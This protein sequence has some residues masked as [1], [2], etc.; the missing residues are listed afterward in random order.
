MIDT[1]GLKVVTVGC[2]GGSGSRLLRDILEASPQIFMDQDC[3]PNSKDSQGSKIFLDLMDAPSET[4]RQLIEDFMQTI[5]RQIP[6]GHESRYKYFGWKNPRN[7]KYVDELLAIHPE[8]RFLHL[9]RDPAV[10]ARGSLWQKGFKRRLANG[11]ISEE[12]NRDELILKRWARQN[13]PLWEK[14]K[15][16]PRYLLVRYEDLINA[17]ATTAKDIFQWLGVKQYEMRQVLS[18]ITPPK[19]ALTRG[20]DVDVSIIAG[21]VRQLGY[22]YRL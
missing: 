12:A 17:P 5:L 13:L 3:S 18:V 11:K 4:I 20:G 10:I 15:D 1:R 19:D 14:Y 9:L 8:L 16:H 6:E 7:R 22:G 21:A 2:T